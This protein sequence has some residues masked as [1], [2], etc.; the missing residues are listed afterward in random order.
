MFKWS[1]KKNRTIN[2]ECVIKWCIKIDKVSF[3]MLKTKILA[4]PL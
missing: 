4:P 3:K 1:A 2:V